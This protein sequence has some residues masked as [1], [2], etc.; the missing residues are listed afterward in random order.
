MKAQGNEGKFNWDINLLFFKITATIST[1]KKGKY[2]IIL[3]FLLKMYCFWLK[4]QIPKCMLMI[5]VQNNL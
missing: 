5:F 3:S 1:A 2:K 4:L